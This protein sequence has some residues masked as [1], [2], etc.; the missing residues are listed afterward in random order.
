MDHDGFKIGTTECVGSFYLLVVTEVSLL[1]SVMSSLLGGG[2]KLVPEDQHTKK[3]PG[4]SLS[5]GGHLTLPQ[6][7]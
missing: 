2:G 7:H 1:F 5:C 3:Q 6:S 4:S